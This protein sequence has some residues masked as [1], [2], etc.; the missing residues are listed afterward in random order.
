MYLQNLK[1]CNVKQ[2]LRDATLI[3]EGGSNTNSLILTR[4][5]IHDTLT[6]E[7]GSIVYPCSGGMFG[8]VSSGSRGAFGNYSSRGSFGGTVT[9]AVNDYCDSNCKGRA[10][11]DKPRREVEEVLNKLR[12]DCHRL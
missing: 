4:H 12:S 8:Y 9:S 2:G 6:R 11:R 3:I 5:F 7:L 10:A 1:A